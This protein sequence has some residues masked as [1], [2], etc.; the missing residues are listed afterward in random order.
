MSLKEYKETIK[1]IDEKEKEY[2]DTRR[3]FDEQEFE[4][5]TTFDFKKE[6]GKDNEKIR[7]QHIRN[8]LSIIADRKDKLK[9]EIDK[10]QRQKTLLELEILYGGE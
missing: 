10:L 6:Y 7:K 8:E 4:I 3:Q 1:L 5:L 2:L 9:L